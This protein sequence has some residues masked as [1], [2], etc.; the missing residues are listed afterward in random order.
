MAVA[1]ASTIGSSFVI[2]G[3]GA[4]RLGVA[5]LTGMALTYVW[6]A[7]VR[8]FVMASA[9]NGLK[10]IDGAGQGK[11]RLFWAMM[12]AIIVCMVS[13]IWML[14]WLSYTRTA[15]SMGMAGFTVAVRGLRT[16]SLP[17]Y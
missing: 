13:S 8:I 6:S 14:L 12:L 15:G 17:R 5:G 2:S 16:I 4:K 11:R 7:D 1:V 3:F 10:V 9:A